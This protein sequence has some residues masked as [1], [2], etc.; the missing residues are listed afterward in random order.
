MPEG[1]NIADLPRSGLVRL[2]HRAD[3][4]LEDADDIQRPRGMD[5]LRGPLVALAD[6]LDHARVVQVPELCVEED[7]RRFVRCRRGRLYGGV[8]ARLEIVQNSVLLTDRA[9]VGK[10]LSWVRPGAADIARDER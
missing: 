10:E 7:G 6:L 9:D 2:A 4:H 1:L 5:L 8:E 3:L